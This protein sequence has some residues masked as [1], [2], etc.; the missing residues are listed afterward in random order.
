M[1]GGGEPSYVTVAGP[2]EP[3]PASSLTMPTMVPTLPDAVGDRAAGSGVG[4]DLCEAEQSAMARQYVMPALSTAQFA[5]EPWSHAGPNSVS[6]FAPCAAT[7]LP[8]IFAAARLQPSDVLWD[9]GCGDGR[10]LHEAAARYGRG[11]LE[12]KHSTSV[13]CSPPP[14]PP[15]PPA[16]L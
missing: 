12:N 6:P 7:R 11:G 4:L 8:H 10:V 9:L 16:H 14:P 1:A 5:E 3:V 13:E 15:P 2:N